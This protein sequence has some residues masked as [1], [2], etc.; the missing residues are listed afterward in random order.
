MTVYIGKDTGKRYLSTV[1]VYKVA[2]A[3]TAEN[4]KWRGD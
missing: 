2:A 4:F 1:L 3:A